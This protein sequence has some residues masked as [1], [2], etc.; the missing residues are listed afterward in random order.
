MCSD[1]Q[2]LALAREAI[3]V[4]PIPSAFESGQTR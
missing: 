2:H 3:G 1:A 4:N